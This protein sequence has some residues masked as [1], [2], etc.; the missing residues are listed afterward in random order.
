MECE[1]RCTAA[2]KVNPLTGNT[3]EETYRYICLW[4]HPRLLVYNVFIDHFL[5]FEE[6][7]RRQHLFLQQSPERWLQAGSFQNGS[8]G[9]WWTAGLC[10][11]SDGPRRSDPC[12][13]LCCWTSTPGPSG[14]CP[15]LWEEKE[16]QRMSLEVWSI[17]NRWHITEKST[18]QAQLFDLH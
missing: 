15:E 10:A 11:Q 7:L 1:Q 9:W 13:G 6:E 4:Q 12:G 3:R 18:H 14:R 5:I 17:W 16:K 2:P 8:T